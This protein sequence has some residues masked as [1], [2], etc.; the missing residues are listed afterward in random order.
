MRVEVWPNI[1]GAN[2]G[3]RCQLPMQTRWA[4]RVAQLCR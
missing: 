3:G 2:A 4:V 1:T